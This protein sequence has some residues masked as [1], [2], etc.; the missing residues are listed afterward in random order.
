MVLRTLSGNSADHAAAQRRVCDVIPAAVFTCDAEGRLTYVN[1]AWHA[2]LGYDDEE[3]LA[4][5][6]EDL[7]EPGTVQAWK[8]AVAQ[9]HAGLDGFTCENQL[10]HRDGS[11]R[12]MACNV[13]AVRDDEGEFCGLLGIAMDIGKRKRGES[14]QVGLR[15]VLEQMSLG[16]GLEPVLYR[17]TQVIE[18]AL[19]YGARASIQFVEPGGKTLQP[20]AAPSLPEDYPE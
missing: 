12:W 5:R 15:D 20:A 6:F 16:S 19:D 4:L 11:A 1:A 10:R 17:L 9:L 2:L 13:R 7:A 18:D 8:A 14:L 3:L